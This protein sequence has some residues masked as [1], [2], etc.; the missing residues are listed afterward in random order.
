MSVKI[1][2][3]DR[4]YNNNNNDCDNN[5]VDNILVTVRCNCREIWHFQKQENISS[6]LHRT[7]QTTLFK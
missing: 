4:Y 7:I 6:A 3:N 1:I 5:N 2:Q